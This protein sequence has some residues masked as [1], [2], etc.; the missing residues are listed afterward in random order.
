MG[1][2]W[3]I[4]GTSTGFG[5]H[6]VRQLL[7]TQ[8]K[9]VATARSLEA[10]ADLKKSSPE[11]VH[12]AAADVTNKEQVERAVKEAVEVFGR[13]DVVVNN[14][15]YGLSGMLEEYTDEQMK[16]QFEVNVF[17]VLNVIRATLPVLKQQRSGHY[18][19]FSSILGAIGVPTLSLYCASKFAVEGFSEAMAQ[20]L[21]GFGIKTTVVEPGVFATD[22]SGR[23]M[24]HA[25]K[26]EEYAPVYEATYRSFS[27]LVPGDPAKAMK[28]VV[29][30]AESENP[31][32]H[33]PVGVG[34]SLGIRDHFAKRIDEIAAWEKLALDTA[35][36]A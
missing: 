24:R 2:V 28:A 15:G 32:L 31:P 5:M 17:G 4:T 6:L 12:I 29:A 30:M 7:P 26:K 16:E 23:S 25:E 18:I 10:I 21:A 8:H 36:D 20:E 14:A 34:A 13:I 27:A 22:F 33:F 9:V 19:N 35:F 1:K 3:L 11:N